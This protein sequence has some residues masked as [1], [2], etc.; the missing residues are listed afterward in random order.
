MSSSS[1]N[2]AKARS[3]Y[4]NFTDGDIIIVS[5]IGTRTWKLHSSIL[6]RVSERFNEILSKQ[7]PRHLTK[8]QKDD[9]TVLWT[10]QMHPDKMDMRFVDFEVVS[11]TQKQLTQ[12]P[13]QLIGMM[14]PEYHR[15]YDMFF[16]CLYNVDP[17]LTKREVSGERAVHECITI[18]VISERLGARNAVRHAI[19][20]HLFRL[21]DDLWDQVYRS[22]EAWCGIA[23][24]LKSPEI[25]REAMIHVSG[26]W[27]LPGKIQ[28]G[29]FND[30]EDGDFI[31]KLAQLKAE[32]LRVKKLLV[33]HRMMTFFPPRMSHTITARSIPGRSTY[34]GDIYKWQSLTLMRQY[35]AER[36]MK[37]LT[38]GAPD[39]GTSF[40]RKLGE[41]GEAVLND[42]TLTE[43]HKLFEMTT[44]GKSIFLKELD[45]M[46]ADFQLIVKDLLVDNLQSREVPLPQPL[47]YL[48]CTIIQ[49]NEMPWGDL[50]EVISDRESEEG[51]VDT[52]EE[53]ADTEEEEVDTEEDDDYHFNPKNRKFSLYYRSG[54]RSEHWGEPSKQRPS[55]RQ[56]KQGGTKASGSKGRAT[57]LPKAYPAKGPDAPEGRANKK[58]VYRSKRQAASKSTSNTFEAQTLERGSRI[59]DAD[60]DFRPTPKRTNSSTQPRITRAQALKKSLNK[61]TEGKYAGEPDPRKPPEP[62]KTGAAV[63]T[64]ATPI[65]LKARN[66][67]DEKHQTTHPKD[68]NT[69]SSGDCPRMASPSG[70]DDISKIMDGAWDV[71]RPSGTADLPPDYY[72]PEILEA[73]RAMVNI[74]NSEE[75]NGQA[76]Q[77]VDAG[78]DKV[79]NNDPGALQQLADIAEQVAP[80]N[81]ESIEGLKD[82]MNIDAGGPM[83]E[84]EYDV[85][86][87]ARA[88]LSTE[89]ADY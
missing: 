36:M 67:T 42:T 38:Y 57:L 45:A 49:D 21:H 80:N 78:E 35:V 40:Y 77:Q 32:Q 16:R 7:A 56:V 14:E 23:T 86:K 79:I 47:P 75:M 27:D 50:Q 8:N 66:N 10:L 54:G 4:P 61:A 22:P 9:Q 29:I 6:R 76:L 33:E 28:R 59:S 12:A 81:F 44:K 84:V 2:P 39:G 83:E 51:E 62:A 26:K 13:V 37:N 15:Y 74:T 19:E 88:L 64:L 55:S 63:R 60:I 30:I 53:E 25:F 73:A 34:A 31:I 69:A 1:A 70:G 41:G 11:M 17:E 72:S 89:Y 20:N 18:L 24:R 85:V 68:D 5:S 43:Y 82:A 65:K 48:T 87:V 52:E 3:E 46:K 58:R 71:M